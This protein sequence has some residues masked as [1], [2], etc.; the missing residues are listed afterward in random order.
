M[1]DEDLCQLKAQ[2]QFPRG[3]RN[4]SIAIAW[5]VIYER[6]RSARRQQWYIA[7][8]AFIQ[9]LHPQRRFDSDIKPLVAL[10][11]CFVLLLVS[12]HEKMQLEC[13]RDC[14]FRAR[15][16]GCF[17]YHMKGVIDINNNRGAVH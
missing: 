10:R 7:K 8:V 17:A 13:A 11:I 6:E 3:V 15:V 14:L 16:Y 1:C 5:K 9:S 4:A 12:T 2:L